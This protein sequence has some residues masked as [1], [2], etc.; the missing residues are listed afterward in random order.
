MSLIGAWDLVSFARTDVESGVTTYPYG[1]DAIGC[2]VY[3]AD[4]VVS[5]QLCASKRARFKSGD[6]EKGEPDELAAAATSFRSYVAHWSISSEEDC[7]V[8]HAVFM[9]IHEDRVGV[10]LR[11]KFSLST[12]ASGLERLILRPVSDSSKSSSSVTEELVWERHRP[13]SA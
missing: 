9:S 1:A 2:I 11:R 13:V 4:G 5:Y 8:S 3:S 12:G 10:T 7:I 6:I